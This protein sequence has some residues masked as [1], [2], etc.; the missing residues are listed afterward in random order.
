MASEPYKLRMP[1]HRS[2]SI[3]HHV[4]SLIFAAADKFRASKID[5]ENNISKLSN[6]SAPRGIELLPYLN[7]ILKE[8][9]APHPPNYATVARLLNLNH[10]HNFHLLNIFR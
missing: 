3:A 4:T 5:Q 8:Q 2:L 7:R 1:R 6:F 10:R 9:A